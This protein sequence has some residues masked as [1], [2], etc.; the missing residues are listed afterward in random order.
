VDAQA[1]RAARPS[2]QRA[3]AATIPVS[4]EIRRINLTF[5][6]AVIASATRS[7]GEAE[8]GMVRRNSFELPGR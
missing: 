4:I 2:P 6:P 5:F 7:R 8:D 3:S 1:R